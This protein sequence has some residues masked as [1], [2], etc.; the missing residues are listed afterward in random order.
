MSFSCGQDRSLTRDMEIVPFV[1]YT[2]FACQVA[3]KYVIEGHDGDINKLLWT[4]SVPRDAV[5]YGC[6]GR[7]SK[8]ELAWMAHCYGGDPVCGGGIKFEF[9][10]Y[11]REFW[12][13]IKFFVILK[14]G[15]VRYM[16]TWL[17]ASTGQVFIVAQNKSEF[18]AYCKRSLQPVSLKKRRS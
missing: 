9:P 8:K 13:R 3:Q 5:K 17:D 12:E 18:F 2:D 1:M 11:L 6:H 7:Y 15:L 16:C 10:S 14:T 4:F